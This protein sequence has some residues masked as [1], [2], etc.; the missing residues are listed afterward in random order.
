[1]APAANWLRTAVDA[2]AEHELAAG[3]ALP[4]G[5]LEEFVRQTSHTGPARRL[6]YEWL[7][8]ADPTAPDRL[9]PGML[10]DRSTALRRDAVARALKEV[11]KILQKGDKPAATAAFQKVFAAAL[12]RD[13]VDETAKQLKALGV[14]VDLAAHF[15]FLRKWLLVGPFDSSG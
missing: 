8:R 7:T 14:E 12:D 3:K 6:A 9:L 4:T 15:G 1:E 10:D 13:Q 2:I 5:K 11:E